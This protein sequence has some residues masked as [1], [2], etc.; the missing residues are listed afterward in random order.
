MKILV[1]GA[2]G[3]IG[4][5]VARE[6]ARDRATL[7]LHYCTNEKAI[8]ELMAGLKVRGL[9]LQSP[10]RTTDE[11]AALVERFVAEAGGIDG[12]AICGG[13]I[14]WKHWSEL[15]RSDWDTMLFE[16]ALAPFHLAQAAIPAMQKQGRGRIVYLSSIAVKYAGSPKTLH[17]AAAK[18]ALE[19]AMKGL[20]KETAKGGIRVNGVRS[21]FVM[22]PLQ[23]QGRTPEELAKRIA[24]I[25][26]GRAG[27]A[28]EVASAFGYLFSESADFVTGEILTVAGG[29]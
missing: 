22:S 21:G 27:E 4:S 6:L 15:T 9:A 23:S 14:A 26:A 10:L 24:M 11:C 19:T 1:I 18:A 2:S 17:Y 25:P 5:A 28:K 16:H 3:T 7:G 12:L 13:T 20:S 29:D 8:K